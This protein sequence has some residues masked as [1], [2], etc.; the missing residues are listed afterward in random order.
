MLAPIDSPTMADFKNNLDRI[1]TLAEKS[2]G[3]VWRLKDEDGDATSI[4]VFDDEFMIINM[5]VWESKK[6][7]FDFTYDSAHVEVFKR[8]KEW[9]HKMSDRHMALW[10]VEEGQNPSPEEAKERL[11][12]LNRLGE[13]P[14]A[15]TFKS[16]F[17]SDDA[18]NYQSKL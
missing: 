1:N 12:L 15:F 10:Y 2:D 18:L 8:R 13:T 7:L 4:K 17:D 16:N 9:F 5:S 3:F 14:F 6:A 11:A